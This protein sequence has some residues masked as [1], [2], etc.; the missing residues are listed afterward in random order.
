MFR[1]FVLTI[2]PQN[3][4]FRGVDP[5]ILVQKH[6]KNS[7]HLHLLLVLI[8]CFYKVQKKKKG[9]LTG[10][11]FSCSSHA[12]IDE[13]ICQRKDQFYWNWHFDMS[14]IHDSCSGVLTP[15]V[16]SWSI[17]FFC[18]NVRFSIFDFLWHEEHMIWIWLWYLPWLQNCKSSKL[19]CPFFSCFMKWNW[20]SLSLKPVK[21]SRANLNH[22]LDLHIIIIKY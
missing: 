7:Y 9:F 22:K 19:E 4:S 12:K 16:K 1:I 5:L 8:T 14:T 13:I 21:I 17:H 2:I 3:I 18:K 6:V 20:R 15:G 10:N 11:W